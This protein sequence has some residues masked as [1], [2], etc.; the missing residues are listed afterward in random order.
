MNPQALAKAEVGA[1]QAYY[2]KNEAQTF[3]DMVHFFAQLYSLTPKQ[4]SSVAQLYAK[5]MTIFGQLP[6][7]TSQAIYS[8]QVL[9][10][11]VKAY[12]QLAKYTMLQHPAQVAADDMAWWVARRS[13]KTDTVR[14]VGKIMAKLYQA[15]YG[16]QGTEGFERASFCFALLRCNIVI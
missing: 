4:A 6:E 13:P 15:I 2:H 7:N 14:Q 8:Q 9:P 11:V 5:A 12:D 16:Q 10:W 3:K 1:W